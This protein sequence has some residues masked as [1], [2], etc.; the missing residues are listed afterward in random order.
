MSNFDRIR[1]P[2][3]VIGESDP[4]LAYLLQRFAEKSGLWIQNA[5]TGEEVVE[6]VQQGRPALIILDPELPGK[7]RGWEAAK[8]LKAD[9]ST[10]RVP[11][12]ICSWL[13]K[14][15]ALVLVN[16]ASGYLSKPDLRY[17]DFMAVLDAAGIKI[18]NS[19]PNKSV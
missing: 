4:F 2:L 11:M 5:Q 10:S 8:T 17:E 9:S 1:D 18:T 16:L 12:I 13:K 7:V 14:T 3:C 19:R 6:L 15:D